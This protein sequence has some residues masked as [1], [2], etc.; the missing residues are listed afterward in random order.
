MSVQ[1]DSGASISGNSLVLHVDRRKWF[2]VLAIGLAF[3]A[4]GIT[5][6]VI[7]GDFLA[8]FCTL[9]FALV[10]GV[11]GVQLVGA[12]SDLELG[13]DVFTVTNFG[14]V[15][16]ERWDEC[17]DFAV[18]R[19][20]YNEQL[21]YDR[22]PDVGTHM[23]EM[24]RTISGRTAGLPDTFGMTAAELAKLMNAYQAF[25]VDR[26]WKRHAEAVDRFGRMMAD[27]L[28]TAG[29]VADVITDPDDMALPEEMA[30]WPSIIVAG[31]EKRPDGS[32]HILI[33]AD[34]LSPTSRWITTD[35]KQEQ[36]FDVLRAD[37]LQIIDPDSDEI[38][39]ISRKIQ[40]SR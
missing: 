6:I 10:A 12:G 31:R 30:R 20:T 7:K 3:V 21:V 1:A 38:R 4:I 26:A 25:G 17:A 36:A 15:T 40:P 33:C 11:A 35:A 23:G 32:R 14:R 5:M 9:F 13:A 27:G 18:Y 37:E 29:T 2:G 34:I 28:E 24:N 8:W 16:T 22:A 19:T 39:R